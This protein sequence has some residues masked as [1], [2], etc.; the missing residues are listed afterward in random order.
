MM[1]FFSALHGEMHRR[2]DAEKY[3]V[4]SAFVLYSFTFIYLFNC[5]EIFSDGFLYR[6]HIF[7][8]IAIGGFI[9]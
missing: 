6:A 9:D 2:F 1:H 4:R 3:E 7:L 8:G 5:S